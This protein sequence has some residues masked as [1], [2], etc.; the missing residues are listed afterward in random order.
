MDE[1]FQTSSS[2]DSTARRPDIIGRRLPEEE[3]KSFTFD[4]DDLKGY[5]LHFQLEVLEEDDN[6]EAEAENRDAQKAVNKKVID[7]I[8]S[9]FNFFRTL[10]NF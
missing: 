1:I 3:R 5:E 2:T 4:D 8:L 7:R 10:Q 9:Q 6:E